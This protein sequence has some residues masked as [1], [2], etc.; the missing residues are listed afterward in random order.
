MRRVL[1]I[2]LVALMTLPAFTQELSKKEQKQ[3]EKELKKEQ[4]AEELAKRAE[5]V[6]AMVHYQRFVLEAN[7]LKDKRGN[8]LNVS[9]NI[10]FIAADSLTGVIQVGSNTYIGRNGVGGVT[11]EGSIADYKYTKHE[12]SGSYSVTY[13]LRTPVGSYDVRLT[14]YP[15]GRADADVSS[16][17]W[18]G[19]L[20]Y[21]GNLVPPGISRVYKGSAL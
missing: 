15:D 5:V 20:R 12:K 1:T 14:A 19:R 18:G 10:N 17:T 6:T 4:K 21:S 3:L 8:S 13:Y 7:M 9:S 11:V 16:T 2:V